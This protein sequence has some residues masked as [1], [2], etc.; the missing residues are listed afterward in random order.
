MRVKQGIYA[1]PYFGESLTYYGRPDQL[2]LQDD[3]TFL[4]DIDLPSLDLD[5][6]LFENSTEGSTNRSSIMSAHSHKSSQSSNKGR[7]G[8]L[9]GLILPSS[10]SGNNDAMEGF[11]LQRS[12]TGSIQN[13]TV[14][15]VMFQEEEGFLP[16]V[17]FN[18][19][20]D[21]NMIELRV[22]SRPVNETG[23]GATEEWNES[24]VTKRVPQESEEGLLVGQQRVRQ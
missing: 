9:P 24:A 13:D 20:A 2:I 7:E 15:P 11:E 17:D 4:P 16:D 5:L 14:L 18:F 19:D 22:Q 12:N 10:G 8:P 3:P 1:L 21:G 23:Q 6:A